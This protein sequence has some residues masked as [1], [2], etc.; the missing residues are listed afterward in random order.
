M[1]REVHPWL[2]LSISIIHPGWMYDGPPVLNDGWDMSWDENTIQ[3]VPAPTAP[4][5]WF[6]LGCEDLLDQCI[7]ATYALKDELPPRKRS[8]MSTR[9]EMRWPT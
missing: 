1:L 4:Q 2:Q 5:D 7:D 6:C 9:C 8:I 3:P